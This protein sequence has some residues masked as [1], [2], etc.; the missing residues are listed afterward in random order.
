MY[1][2]T[3]LKEKENDNVYSQT[4]IHRE[5]S[6][7]NECTHLHNEFFIRTNIDEENMLALMAWLILYTIHWIPTYITY[8]TRIDIIPYGSIKSLSN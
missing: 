2:K 1:Y 5:W 6:I 7:H 4:G 3:K 8:N